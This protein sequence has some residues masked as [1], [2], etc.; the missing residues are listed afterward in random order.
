MQDFDINGTGIKKLI[1]ESDIEDQK[2]DQVF[3][4][5][6]N[7]TVLKIEW[8]RELDHNHGEKKS[9]EVFNALESQLDEMCGK[10][11]VKFEE[12]KLI[13]KQS[14]YPLESTLTCQIVV[15]YDY[16]YLIL[17][18]RDNGIATIERLKIQKSYQDAF[19]PYLDKWSEDRL[20]EDSSL[21]YVTHSMNSYIDGDI[22]QDG[23]VDCIIEWSCD[24]SGALLFSGGFSMLLGKNGKPDELKLDGMITGHPLCEITEIDDE[25]II[26]AIERKYSGFRETRCC[27]SIEAKRRFMLYDGEFIEI[28]NQYRDNI[29]R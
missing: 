7:A 21:N 9:M 18:N 5:I 4:Y 26:Y 10:S 11:S 28:A 20:Q 22:D 25:G 8:K 13:E 2:N 12:D 15:N 14:F 19:Q 3:L 23:T 1:Y 27:P 17:M 24:L 16:V 6:K 29:I